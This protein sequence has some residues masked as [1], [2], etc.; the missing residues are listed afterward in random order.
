VEIRMILRG[1]LAERF[2]Y[3]MQKY[4]ATTN[5][6]L[7][8]VLVHDK[9]NELKERSGN[10]GVLEEETIILKKVAKMHAACHEVEH[11]PETVEQ[12]IEQVNSEE[13]Q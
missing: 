1:I 11:D 10:P 12:L 3:L 4:G 2:A 6:S 5:A 8:T 13:S 9:Y 7:V